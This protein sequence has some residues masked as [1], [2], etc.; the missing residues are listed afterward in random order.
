MKPA[1]RQIESI[2]AAAVEVDSEVE[3]RGWLPLASGQPFGV[4]RHRLTICPRVLRSCQP[5]TKRLLAEL[6]WANAGRS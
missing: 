2:L 4:D 6:S 5:R 3:R 1:S